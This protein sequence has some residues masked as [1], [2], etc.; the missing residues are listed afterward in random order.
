MLRGGYLLSEDSPVARP[1]PPN[2]A[3]SITR[4]GAAWRAWGNLR[5]V[6]LVALNSSDQALAVGMVLDVLDLHGWLLEVAVLP[7]ARLGQ[8][9]EPRQISSASRRSKKRR[10]GAWRASSSASR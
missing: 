1:Y 8:R 9:S 5:D 3:L 2:L 4:Q 7:I 10:S 6:L